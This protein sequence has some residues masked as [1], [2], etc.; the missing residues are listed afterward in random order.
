MPGA[1]GSSQAR[2]WIGATALSYAT[3]P[4]QHGIW[5]VSV[6]YTTAQSHTG[7]LTHWARLG[8][9]PGS[10]WILVRFIPDEPPWELWGKPFWVSD[11][12]ADRP[13]C[14]VDLSHCLRKSEGSAS[15]TLAYILA[16]IV[17]INP[18][19][20]WSPARCNVSSL[21]PHS[22]TILAL[23]LFITFISWKPLHML[24]SLPQIHFTQFSFLIC[25]VKSH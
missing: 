14:L 12:G 8:I 2:G 10:S 5:A 23:I 20:T 21:S 6:T 15:P 17:F 24:L 19:S 4:Q 22:M 16:T 1:Y 13:G 25:L 3:K 18:T 11:T 7:F 9:K